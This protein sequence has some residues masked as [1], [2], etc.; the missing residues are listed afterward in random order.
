MTGCALDEALFV[1]SLGDYAI[2]FASLEYIL[3]ETQWRGQ[4]A[5]D[6]LFINVLLS[7]QRL[8]VRQDLLR[9][10][11]LVINAYGFQLDNDVA[12]LP[13]KEQVNISSNRL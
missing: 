1:K 13:L 4:H 8:L 6:L 7:R 12:I 3:R 2:L 9:H 11:R 5:N 10:S